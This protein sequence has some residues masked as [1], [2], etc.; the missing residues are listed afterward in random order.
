MLFGEQLV[1]IR[2][3]LENISTILYLTMREI[4]M[5]QN[6]NVSATSAFLSVC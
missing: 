2:Q 1:I 4:L 5:I 3:K 6:L